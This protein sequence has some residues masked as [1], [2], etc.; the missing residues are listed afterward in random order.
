M[1]DLYYRHQGLQGNP[2]VVL[3]HGLFGSLENL[4]SVAKALAEEFSVY[5]VDLRNHGRSPHHEMMNYE[6]MANDVIRFLD[7]LSLTQVMILGHSMGGKVAMEVALRAPDRISGLIVADIAPIRYLPHHQQ[8][9]AGLQALTLSGIT[10]RT[11]ADQDLSAYVNEAAVRSF[12]L[13]NLVKTS[14]SGFQWRMN[15]S[16]IAK[17]Y[18]HIMAGQSSE[19]SYEKPVL[20]IKG[21]TSD[22]ILPRHQEVILSLFPAAGVKIIQNAGHWLHAEKPTIFNRLVIQ[23]LKSIMSS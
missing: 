4:G 12:L 20:F 15:L 17:H 19:S 13:K 7:S 10:S 14:A 6:L 3:L 8:V 18:E 23:F 16:A 21:G 5:S 2:P 22:Y 11:Q 9:F 1:L